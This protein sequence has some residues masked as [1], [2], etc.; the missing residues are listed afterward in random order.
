M[1]NFL[2]KSEIREILLPVFEKNRRS[3]LFGYLFGSAASSKQTPL[4]DV[5]IAI[6]VMDERGFSFSD[7]LAF[8]ADCC[9]VLKTSAVDVVVLNKMKNIML[10]DEIVRGGFVLWDEEPAIR[11]F[12]DLNIMHKCMDFSHQ[13]QMIF[14]V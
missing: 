9:R 11:E 7:K 2:K 13:H 10:L 1:E 4:S 14:G 5:D 12:F 3:I 6:S 8:H